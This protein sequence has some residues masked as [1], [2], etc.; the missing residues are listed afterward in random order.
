[1]EGSGGDEEYV[2]GSDHAVARVD[3][4]AL[5]DGQKVALHALAR[6]VGPR[7]RL[8]A[9]DLVQLVE[10]DYAVGLDAFQ[11]GARDRVHVDEPLLLLLYDVLQGL[12][13][14]H[15][16]A[17]GSALKEVAEHVLH[18]DAHHLDA[19]R[20]GDLYGGKTLLAH[21]HLDGACV[22]LTFAQLSAKLLARLL[23]LF[24]AVGRRGRRIRARRVVF[25]VE[26]VEAGG[27]AR[28]EQKVQDALFGVEFSL[29]CDFL[30][31][32]GANHVDGNFGEIAYHALHVSTDVADLCELRGFDLEEGRVGHAREAA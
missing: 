2:I 5:D 30:D 27:G 25:G 20:P 31:L 28:G 17:L 9:R 6:N 29:L 13:D 1:M 22:E 12:V 24:V 21:L 10:K 23:E 15:A 16:L 7:A 14:A 3:G 32:L 18:V 19:L 8:T 11:G 26:G 4:R